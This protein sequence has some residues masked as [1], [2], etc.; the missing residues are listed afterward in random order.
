MNRLA[1]KAE[2]KRIPITEPSYSL[3][4]EPWIGVVM[5]NGDF[6]K[7]GLIDFFRNLNDISSLMVDVGMEE[8]ALFRLLLAIVYRALDPVLVDDWKEWWNSGSIP[9]DRIIEYLNAHEDDFWL[10]HPTK[11]FLQ[12]MVEPKPGLPRNLDVVVP[13]PVGE[14]EMSNRSSAKI[15][16]MPY[17]ELT[18]RIIAGMQYDR[19][20]AHASYVGAVD[21]SSNGGCYAGVA[22][23]AQMS[24]IRLE[25]GSM[26]KDLLL[27]LIPL[28]SGLYGFI[29]DVDDD[30]DELTA[31]TPP[32]E[33][34]PIGIG[35][36][37]LKD[38]PLVPTTVE[39]A[40]V[41]MGRRIRIFRYDDGVVRMLLSPGR[42][43]SL[44]NQQNLEPMASFVFS[45]GKKDKTAALKPWNSS[46]TK[47][48][49]RS[50]AS[51]LGAQASTKNVTPMTLRWASQLVD[52]GLL[53][54]N[55][56]G[57]VSVSTVHFSDIKR[58]KVVGFTK[59]SVQIPIEIV[60]NPE[61]VGLINRGV[62]IAEDMVKGYGNFFTELRMSEGRGNDDARKDSF[63]MV[64]MAYDLLGNGFYSWVSDLPNL[65]DDAMMK[66][67]SFARESLMRL[68]ERD[69]ESAS[70]YSLL[71][72]VINDRVYSSVNALNKFS[73]RLR[74]ITERNAIHD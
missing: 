30:D 3:L 27:S 22:Y 52:D 48:F 32:W 59:D 70:P 61:Y 33:E 44:K 43:V 41:W 4:H 63:P 58:S 17:D 19:A 64:S 36:A 55:Y 60:D 54:S 56:I 38:S 6:R 29:D 14:V 62:S 42:H 72:R 18:L 39:Q 45:D 34:P 68:A 16:S 7:M 40:L 46:K 73:N 37:G 15:N 1:K 10:W 2:P 23:L 67:I 21:E 5:R 25:T 57:N 20:V 69:V 31:G 35:G 28:D 9:V 26:V 24:V 11:P 53:P 74:K 47:A 50:M 66:W 12:S 71:G 49:W 13:E 51:L 8:P 65:E